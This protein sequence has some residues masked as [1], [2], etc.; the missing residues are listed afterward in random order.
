MI[1]FALTSKILITFAI[2]GI[3]SAFAVYCY[4]RR[5]AGDAMDVK[6][7]FEELHAVRTFDGVIDVLLSG[8]R[9]RGVRTCGFFRKN[10]LTDSLEC[11]DN[12]VSLFIRS[13]AV[14][15][16]FTMQPARLDGTIEIDASMAKKYGK[17]IVFIPV[18]MQ[19]DSACWKHNKCDSGKCPCHGRHQM[20]CWLRSGKNYRGR[21]LSSYEDKSRKCVRCES[22]LPVGVFAV[23]GGKAS[24]VMSFIN[25]NFSGVL[26][27]A[28]NYERM[29]FKATR[30]SLTGIMNR[31]TF[32]PEAIKLLKLA[33]RYGDNI[34]L[35]MLDIDHFKTFNDTYGHQTGDVILRSL[36]TLLTNS[37]RDT[38]IAARYGG[39]EF[40]IVLPKTSKD[41][42][43]IVLDK[44]RSIVHDHAFVTDKGNLHVTISMGVAS[45]PEDD[46]LNVHDLIHK[47]DIALYQAKTTRNRVMPYN[48]DFPEIPQE[49]KKT[50]SV[51]ERPISEERVD[52][53]P[54]AEDE[55]DKAARPQNAP[56][57]KNDDRKPQKTQGKKAVLRFYGNT[58]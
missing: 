56:P 57:D 53:R 29:T 38:D 19:Q 26:R 20:F 54:P 48:K 6:S 22:F 15:A 58:D 23:K 17:D 51:V 9:S 12:S 33:Q 3:L 11:G 52:V 47:A 27:N 46:T 32:V 10:L 37:L 50:E 42:A 24:K 36:A 43:L 30:D 1:E 7:L 2:I 21:I 16:F 25:K 34:S 28:V 31:G 44:I 49:E 35:C 41:N 55:K 14:K 8:I 4:F 45:F 40:V 39:E 18:A 5:K 13:A